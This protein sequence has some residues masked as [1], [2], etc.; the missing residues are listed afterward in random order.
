MTAIEVWVCTR[1]GASQLDAVLAA[2]AAAGAEPRLAT[3]PPG[4][5]P[6][7][8]RNEA[9]A[10]CRSEVLA[11]VDD[12]VEVV[13]GWLE[14]LLETWSG[15][16]AAEL[17]CAGGPLGAEFVGGRPS[18]LGDALLPALGVDTGVPGGERTFYGGNVS[19]RAA[20]LRG[21]GG[22]WPARGVPGLR[23]RFGEEHRAQHE[24]ARAGWSSAF[25]PGAGAVRRIA[26]AESHV[27]DVL[28][29]RARYGARSA[30][31]G[32]ADRPAAVA[33]AAAKAVAGVPVAAAQRDSAK[34]VERAVRAAQNAGALAAPVLA[35]RSLQPA[36]TRTP[37]LHS[38]APAAP[39]PIRRVV[40]R[41]VSGARRLRGGAPIVLLYHRVGT[42]GDDPLALRVSPQHFAQQLEVLGTRRTPVPLEQIVAGEAPRGAVAVTVDDGYADIVEEGLPALEAAGVPA[43]VFISTG[44]VG[45]GKAFWWD[46]LARL[47]RAAPAQAGP[48]ELTVDGDTRVW[49]AHDTAQ[50]ALTF[51]YLV[52]WL[53][54]EPPEAIDAALETIARWAGLDDPLFPLPEDRPMTVHELRRLAASPMVTIG[55]HGVDHACMATQTPER[56]AVEL[57]KARDDLSG[58]LGTPP[59]GFAYPYGVP[60]VDVDAATRHATR[61]A[62]TPTASSTPP[63]PC[64]GARTRW[65]CPAQRPQTPARTRSTPGCADR[66]WPSR[67]AVDLAR[68]GSSAVRS[69][70]A[71]RGGWSAASPSRRGRRAGERLASKGKG[72]VDHVRGFRTA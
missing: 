55:S 67:L 42:A 20:A 70:R 28:L 52:A 17:A 30:A 50:R 39:G 9:L 48:L 19:F 63:G 32:E 60:G 40:P 66:R 22:F 1:P 54:V 33:T 44:H 6:A 53:R 34:T 51:R 62:A 12:D 37:F 57:A 21:V 43:T 27:R 16:G 59:A 29:L 35:H 3:V 14:A 8:A 4:Q 11:L 26:S 7:A 47:L 23:D 2:L 49:P 61:A 36:V 58:W 24:L 5:G 38:V 13:E 15:P 18:W 72:A 46:A 10:G 25:V 65:R 56:R 68:V 45:A 31:V 69:N 71:R 41:V 64:P